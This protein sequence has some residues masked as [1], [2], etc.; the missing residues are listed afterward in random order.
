M[1]LIVGHAKL[2]TQII[3]LLIVPNNVD[4][5]PKDS[6]YK[7]KHTSTCTICP[8]KCEKFVVFCL[9]GGRV[10]EAMVWENPKSS[11]GWRHWHCRPLWDRCYALAK[12][13]LWIWK[14]CSILLH[15]LCIPA[16]F[17]C[18]CILGG[19]EQNVEH[20]ICVCLCWQSWI[21]CC[22]QH[23]RREDAVL[24]NGVKPQGPM[25]SQLIPRSGITGKKQWWA[26][27]NCNAHGGGQLH[28]HKACPL[29]TPSKAL[30][31]YTKKNQCRF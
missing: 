10:Q 3:S 31:K 20:C 4:F 8:S 14:R 13:H 26:F 7:N 25:G 24:G 19:V 2:H 6:N 30:S 5:L 15:V 11:Q 9:S 22:K 12:V 1:H 28:F 29:F 27:Q 18:M 16:S 17:V 21:F 23:S